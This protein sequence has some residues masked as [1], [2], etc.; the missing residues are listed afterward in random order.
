MIRTLDFCGAAE[1]AA[2]L[3]TREAKMQ[4]FIFKLMCLF[5]REREGEVVS[6][7]LKV[8]Y[9]TYDQVKIHVGLLE[10]PPFS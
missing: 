8:V 4:S 3:A 10:L 9:K 2:A 6:D 1:K 5:L 7:Q